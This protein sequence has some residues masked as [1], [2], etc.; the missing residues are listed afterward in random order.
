[1]VTFVWRDR[2]L[3]FGRR[4]APVLT[5]VADATYPHL[6]RITYPNGWTSTPGNLTR[7]KAYG[8]AR[9]LL[10]QES[11]SEACRGPKWGPP[12]GPR[13]HVPA[14]HSAGDAFQLKNC[15]QRKAPDRWRGPG[16]D[17]QGDDVKHE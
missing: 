4:K 8:H 2:G 14:R 15:T 7:A 9:H 5:L 11:P 16:L 6:Y 1:M 3:H 13:L 17:N 12:H 10:G